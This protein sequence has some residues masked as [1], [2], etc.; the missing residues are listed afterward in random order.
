MILEKGETRIEN[1]VGFHLEAL[2]LV[3]RPGVRAGAESSRGR[4]GFEGTARLRVSALTGT[5]RVWNP[6]GVLVANVAE[7]SAVV[8][9][10]QPAAVAAATKITGVL[11]EQRGHF[12]LTD[13]VTRVTVEIT[14]QRL[15]A[16]VGQVVGV[17]GAIKVAATSVANAP[18]VMAASQVQPI[19]NG[20]SAAV[21]GGVSAV[22]SR[23]KPE[24]VPPGPPPGRPKGPPPGRPKGPPET[25]PGLSR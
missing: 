11:T 16:Y 2:G 24:D 20:A 6:R 9:E 17:T 8:F 10:P 25:P 15:G 19:G 5:L 14:G 21:V 12:M 13:R 22:E 4:I 3:V 7:G 23:A 1:L 18:Q